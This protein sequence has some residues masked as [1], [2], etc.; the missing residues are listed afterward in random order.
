MVDL[1]SLCYLRTW[2]FLQR[3]AAMETSS[4]LVSNITILCRGIHPCGDVIW[5]FD[6]NLDLIFS[7][8]E[9]I[10]LLRTYQTLSDENTEKVYL[11]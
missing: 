10:H 7:N 4:K 1:C 6:F 3:I 8:G 11:F 9:H 2:Y 5:N